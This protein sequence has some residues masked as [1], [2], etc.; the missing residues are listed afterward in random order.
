MQNVKLLCNFGW[1]T[2]GTKQ[3]DQI[4]RYLCYGWG[5]C[6]HHFM[7]HLIICLLLQLV[8]HIVGGD[9]AKLLRRSRNWARVTVFRTES[10]KLLIRP[11]IAKPNGWAFRIYTNSVYVFWD[12]ESLNGSSSDGL[13]VWRDPLGTYD[14]MLEVAQV[15]ANSY[16]QSSRLCRYSLLCGLIT[17]GK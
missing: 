11:Y 16:A 6:E 1:R 10:R 2:L 17:R 5:S 7:L 13:T 8:E 12:T 4:V 9:S 3:D 14:R 15:A